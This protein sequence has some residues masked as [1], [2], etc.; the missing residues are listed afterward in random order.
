MKKVAILPGLLTTANFF[1]GMLAMTFIMR[2]QYLYAAESCLVAMLFD[3]VDGYVARLKGAT[4]PSTKS[5]SI[6]TRHDSAA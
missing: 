1:C 6:A 5:K 3:F 2:S 4:Y